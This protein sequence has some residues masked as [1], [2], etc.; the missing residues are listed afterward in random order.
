[1]PIRSY[2]KMARTRMESDDLTIRYY[3]CTFCGFVKH[4]NKKLKGCQEMVYK[5]S[6][7]KKAK[8]FLSDIIQ[9]HMGKVIALIENERKLLSEWTA[10]V[11]SAYGISYDVCD[12]IGLTLDYF[13]ACRGYE[14][15]T[16][17]PNKCFY[18]GVGNISL[19]NG[20]GVSFSIRTQDSRK[21]TIKAIIMYLTCLCNAEKMDLRNTPEDMQN[22]EV[23][24]AG[25]NAV[26]A[27]EEIIDLLA[28]V[29]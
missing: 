14:H 25:E 12:E 17:N 27:L 3:M 10:Y 8:T 16:V 9:D 4:C 13:K 22:T 18:P 26:E 6:F 11:Y 24:E 2:Y 15:F 5:N 29:Y 28:D 23:F 21:D 1:M 19:H 20:N 7:D